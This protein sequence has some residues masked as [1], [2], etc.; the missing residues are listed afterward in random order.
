MIKELEKLWHVGVTQLD[1]LFW[2]VR[3]ASVGWGGDKVRRGDKHSLT[4]SLMPADATS[5]APDTMCCVPPAA[6]LF[7]QIYFLLFLTVQV[8]AGS[9]VF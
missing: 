4:D 1:L 9:Q 8:E 7:R 6:D 2:C 5:L 3:P